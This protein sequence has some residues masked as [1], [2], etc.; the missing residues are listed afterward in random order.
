MSPMHGFNAAMFEATCFPVNGPIEEV[1]AASTVQSLHGCLLIL[2]WAAD[3]F[4]GSGR[5]LSG[6]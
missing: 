4:G 1:R 5:I 6:L 3:R 2:W